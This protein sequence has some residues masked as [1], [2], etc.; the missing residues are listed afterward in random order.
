M[1][2]QPHARL[3]PLFLVRSD[4]VLVCVALLEV[5]VAIVVLGS[6]PIKFKALLLFWLAGSFVL[7]RLGLLWLGW[8]DSCRCLG[9]A[10]NL[11]PVNKQSLDWISVTL[12]IYL[13]V[14]AIIV[15]ASTFVI[16]NSED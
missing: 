1:N 3:D 12:L 6:R 4:L 11:I 9:S 14:G 15:F 8:S 10:I 13:M 7:Y 16:N 5:F 2:A